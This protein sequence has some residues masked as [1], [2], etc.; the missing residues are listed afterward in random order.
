MKKLLLSFL[1]LIAAVPLWAQYFEFE[2]IRYH[3][4]DAEAKTVAVTTATSTNPYSGEVVIPAAITYNGTTYSVTE[5]EKKAFYES[6][7]VGISVPSTIS[8]IGDYAFEYCAS[9]KHVAIED[10]TTTLTL[11]TD[12]FTFSPFETLYIGRDLYFST[13]YTPFSYNANGNN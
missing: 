9:L 4:T 11:G 2:S 8:S 5:I 10:G 3:I 7:I 1:M 13:S 12:L 6:E